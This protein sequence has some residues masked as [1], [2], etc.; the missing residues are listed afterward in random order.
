MKQNRSNLE[1]LGTYATEISRSQSIDDV[2]WVTA[3]TVVDCLNLQDCVIYMV[4]DMRNLLVQCSAAGPKAG[5]DR[6]IIDPIEIPFGIGIVGLALKEDRTICVDD[7][8]EDDRY[9]VDDRSRSSELAVPFSVKGR[10]R[11]VIDSEHAQKGFYKEYH[12]SVFELIA[13]IMGMRIGQLESEQE[14]NEHA[15]FHRLNPN[16]VF[17]LALDG[18]LLDANDA[19]YLLLRDLMVSDAPEQHAQLRENVEDAVLND[20]YVEFNIESK[21][22]TFKVQIVPVSGLNYVNLYATDVSDLSEARRTAQEANAAKADFLSVISHELRTPLNAVQGIAGLLRRTELTEQQKEYLETLDQSSRNL[23][24]LVTDILDFERLEAGK[25]SLVETTFDPVNSLKANLAAFR[26]EARDK[27][28]D[29]HIHFDFLPD[30]KIIV[31]ELRLLQIV[32][33]LVGNAVKYTDEGEV[34]VK[35]HLDKNDEDNATLLLEVS[36]T[37]RGI[38]QEDLDR[39]FEP[40]TQINA[41]TYRPKPGTGLGLAI[42]SRLIR[43]LKGEISVQSTEGVGSVFSVRIPVALTYGAEEP[44]FGGA[45]EDDQKVDLERMR[46]LVVDDNEVNVKVI[47]AY[48][49][50]WNAN[51][52]S[53]PNGKEAVDYLKEGSADII[54][55]D[56][57]MPVL[58]GFET[59]L[60]LRRTEKG[61]GIPV[62]GLSADVTHATEVRALEV[63][64]DLLLTK[65]FDPPQLASLLQ[66]YG[67]G[68]RSQ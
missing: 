39:I 17:R 68:L 18:Q 64:M 31:D 59:T 6:S 49:K 55:M 65:P 38:R 33:N 1:L 47:E 60:A 45:S 10:P 53:V 9:V 16:P 35:A 34:T 40:F 62:L 30:D 26:A 51:V 46:V 29:L 24:L 41:N 36:D 7:T 54:I 63:G 37:G 32:N 27:N 50:M 43:L 15:I 66:S 19:S 25:L 56:I 5:T 58:D 8:S 21:N 3:H 12:C 28:I 20:R 11:G 14:R 42:T 23:T 48:L 57:Q 52:H 67:S 22:R 4:D 61:R 13:A 2:L 44:H